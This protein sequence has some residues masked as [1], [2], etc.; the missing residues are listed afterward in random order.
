MLDSGLLVLS[1]DIV[2]EDVLDVRLAS[3]LLTFQVHHMHAINHRCAHAM[4]TVL[5]SA[6][7]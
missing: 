6:G 3:E 7:L 5:H 1:S 2:L 4:H